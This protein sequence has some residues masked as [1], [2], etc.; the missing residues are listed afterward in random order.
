LEVSKHQEP[1]GGGT[2]LT[3]KKTVGRPQKIQKRLF[4][5][6]KNSETVLQKREIENLLIPERPSIH[7][8]HSIVSI[9]ADKKGL[10]M[11]TATLTVVRTADE[12]SDKIG[13]ALARNEPEHALGI[14][15]CL[16][17]LCESE[18]QYRDRLKEMESLVGE[19]SNRLSTTACRQLSSG[20]AELE[21]LFTT[22]VA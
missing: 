22:S 5:R 2:K 12:A 19:H 15:Q 10:C 8:V 14:A 21:E 13:E 6:Y 11:T 16:W 3:V 9:G 4:R 7:S 17:A 18:T 1:S 20:I